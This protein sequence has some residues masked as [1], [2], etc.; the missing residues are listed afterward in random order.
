VS[1]PTVVFAGTPGFAERSLSALLE[2][3]V[4]PSLVLTQPDRPAGRGRRLTESPVKSCALQ[5]GLDVRQPLSLKAD[6][7]TDEL[8]ALQPDVMIVAAY[9]LLL[10]P[11]ILDIPRIGCLNVHASL[12]PRWRGAAPIQAAILAG[13]RQ[14]GICLM[15]ME[16]GLDTG[17]VYASAE[18]P[19]DDRATAGDVHDRLAAL[20]GELLV[21][22]LPAILAGKLDACPQDDAQ[23]TFAP[24]IKTSDAC[25]DWTQPAER[26]QRLVRAYNPVPGA[27][28]TYN[29]ELIKCWQAE[30]AG[31]NGAP[32]G[33]LL[34]ASAAGVVVAC[35]A[36]SLRMTRLQRAGRKVVSAAEFVDQLELDVDV[37]RHSFD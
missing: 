28:C 23:A 4:R 22:H 32:P 9:G 12:L 31:E 35:G 29:D 16:A 33:R 37:E 20:G 10:P 26:L 6:E 25:I 30:V 1:Q 3:G 7:I 14:T 27:R 15:Q 19:I 17:P 21:E 18:V 8:R 5:H 11:V 36:G 24:K 2:A 13:D 34:S